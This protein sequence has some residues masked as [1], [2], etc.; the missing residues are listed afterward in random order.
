MSSKAYFDDHA[1]NYREALQKGLAATGENA[2]YFAKRRVQITR[3][4]LKRFSAKIVKIM[5]FGC[6]L[7]TAAPHLVEQLDPESVV[8]VDVSRAILAEAA[9]RNRLANV[10]FLHVD[11]FA[12]AADL[13]FTSGVFHHI[14]PASRG[15]ALQFV[16]ST[17]RV[18]GFFAFWENNPLNPGTRYVMN[19][20]EFDRDALTITPAN[21]C[22]LLR[23]AGFEIVGMTSAFFF[24]RALAWLRGSEILLAPTFLGGQY[25]VLARRDG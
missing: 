14:P 8:C 23:S 5:D 2:E 9:A 7:G 4:K 16:R 18:G 21:A 3:D 13:V 15:Q 22:K 17:L 12:G 11:E 6:G 19:R 25:L 20:I 1:G 10:S 24:P